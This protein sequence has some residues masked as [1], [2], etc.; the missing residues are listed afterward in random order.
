MNLRIWSIFLLIC[1]S[2]FEGIA[3][4]MA[5]E[6]WKSSDWDDFLKKSLIPEDILAPHNSNLEFLKTAKIECKASYEKN[7]IANCTSRIEGYYSQ[8]GTGSKGTF[9]SKLSDDEY[10]KLVPAEGQSLPAELN[11]TGNL[12]S[13]WREIVEK[14][15]WSFVHFKSRTG[16]TPRLVIRVPGEKYDR[17][18]V[19]YSWH[20]DETDPLKY[21]NLQVQIISKDGKPTKDGKPEIFFRAYELGPDFDK[22]HSKHSITVE[23]CI[24]CHANGPRMIVPDT[25]GNFP[26]EMGG[27]IKSL[28]TFNDA[29]AFEKPADLDP[30]Y[31]LKN[32]PSHLQVGK[33]CVFCHD[34]DSR[35]SLA[36]FV[37]Q[38]GRLMSFEF[39][40][41]VVVEETMPRENYN[42]LDH[43]GREDMVG[44]LKMDY[45]N[46]LRD[47]LTE[48]KCDPKSQ[49]AP[50]GSPESGKAEVP[51]N[52]EQ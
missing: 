52:V 22:P 48:T 40:R 11:K 35:G 16:N 31:N 12:P 29:I 30:Y 46:K 45:A 39:H 5:C 28:N 13:N 36:T 38:R 17:L 25:T 34:G 27:K 18:L 10:A 47:W 33:S 9:S 32:F 37:E 7:N 42:P 26:F 21:E 20:R 3:G 15:G 14:N 43:K 19:Y 24:G 1:L 51:A 41:K 4:G 2:S 6:D 23:R 8:F 44:A 49:T 50:S